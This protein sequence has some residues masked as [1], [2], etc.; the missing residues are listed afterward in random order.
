MQNLIQDVRYSLRMFRKT[1]GFTAVAVLI[2]ALGIG[3]NTAVFSIINALLLRPLVGEDAGDLVGVHSQG[4]SQ[5][6]GYRPF[7]YPNYQDIRGDSQIFSRLMA[8]NFALV[9]ITEGDTTRRAFAAVVS[10]NYFSTLGVALAR[11][12]AFTLEEET[13]ASGT[14][15]TIV[16][17]EYWRKTAFDPVLVGKAIRVNARNVTIVGIAPEGFTGTMALVSP[18]LWFPLGMYEVVINDVFTHGNRMRLDDRE[19]HALILVGR[20]KPGLTA[21]SA[22]PM[23]RT[24][25]ERMERAF[26]AENKDQRLTVHPLPRMSVSDSPQTDSELTIATILLM[27][28]AGVVLLIACLNLANMMLARGAARR[29]EIAVRLALGGGRGRIVR[30]L[31]TEGLTLSLAGA[32]AGL[33]LAFWSTKLL[34]AS[35]TSLTSLVPFVINF[36]LT[37][38][39]RVLA[40]TMAFALCSTLFFG[41]GPAWTLARTDMLTDLKEQSGEHRGG[42]K[43]RRFVAR[44]MLVVGQIALSLALLTAGGLF[45]RGAFKAATADPGFRLERGLLVGVDPSLAGYDETASR[46]LYRALLERV[47]ALPGVE[48]ASMASVVPFGEFSEGR[49]VQKAGA[50]ST[51][52][53]GKE[54]RDEF[55]DAQYNIIGA[56]YFESL[57]LGVLRGRDFTHQEEESAAGARVVIVDEPLARRLFPEQ[58]PIG[59]QIQ[60]QARERGERPVAMEIVG[61]VPGLRHD[62]F[63]HAPVPHV[64]VP[65]GQQYR[66]NMNLHARITA[67]GREA[68]AAMLG[69]VRREIRALDDRLPVVTLKTLTT[70]RDASLPLWL[71]RTGANMFTIFGLLALGLAVVGVYGVKAYVVSRRTREIGIRMAL[72]AAPADVLWMILREGL[73]LTLAG[74]GVGLALATI[75]ARLLS[76]LLY[77]VSAFD[78]VIFTIAPLVLAAAS[79]LACYLPARRATKVLPLSALRTE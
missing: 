72:G 1:P 31:L 24:L 51:D 45:I 42:R 9:G 48:A 14:E 63:D 40:A 3:A 70:H 50:A 79:L 7:S 11:G 13:P 2:L 21:A 23:L 25:G 62:L 34:I 17:H 36:D 16:S 8:H 10:S 26:P 78:P 66:A 61:L 47:R 75:T 59:R 18:E 4:R 22:A 43:G 73:V 41:L 58:D 74:L 49:H 77:E 15:V 55:A 64:Y 37:P 67:A 39:V 30:Q 28:V 12:R 76:S 29:K 44:N 65:F 27:A 46:S 53:S 56:R 52:R 60:F 33:L 54:A 5:P 68:E 38:D 35:F 71:V 69:S 20:L 6:D 57:G 19:N 32:A